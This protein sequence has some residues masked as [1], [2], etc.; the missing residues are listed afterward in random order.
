MRFSFQG[1]LS[2]GILAL[3][4]G[5][6]GTAPKVVEDAAPGVLACS[7]GDQSAGRV[8][9]V[10]VWRGRED[11][12]SEYRMARVCQRLLEV[13]QQLLAQ[14]VNLRFDVLGAVQIH[15]GLGRANNHLMQSIQAT[16]GK[17][18]L[19][20]VDA[21]AQCGD[22]AGYILGCT[23]QLGRPVLY[24]K[25][26]DPNNDRAPEWVIW[27][28]E[29][30]HAAALYHPDAPGM[31]TVPERIMTYMPLP[32]STVLADYESASFAQLGSIVN[33]P[34]MQAAMGSR[35]GSG[36]RIN[37]EQL[38]PL[39]KEAGPH[40]VSLS[41]LTHL[42]DS[43][44]LTL[45]ALLEPAPTAVN[46][47]ASQSPGLP[48]RINALVL[49]AELG[50]REAQAYV[51]QYLRSQS[52]AQT[53]NIRLYGL[54]ALGR[55]QQRNPTEES[56]TFLAQATEEKFWCDAGQQSAQDCAALAEAA[57]DALRDAQT[58]P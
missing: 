23:P 53:L 20:I 11:N 37:A 42:D 26:H 21:I 34:R 22:A 51:R 33:M 32:Q 49:L 31:V 47:A 50:K 10:E 54:Q 30:G 1:I 52:G 12:L 16:Q 56:L 14:G 18:K 7:V 40:G 2:I 44:L 5:C 39:V 3:I 6:N 4:T 27:A 38:L 55:G 28:H 48:V 35:Q 45:G 17:L 19:V 57:R 24:A 41:Q 15:S 8:I 29:M 36:G 43:A 46:A 9:Q 58:R 25:K 13:S